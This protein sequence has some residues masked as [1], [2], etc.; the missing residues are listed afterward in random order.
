MPRA[1]SPAIPGARR[2][3]RCRH[4]PSAATP[5]RRSA[6][7]L[8]L[9]GEDRAGDLAASGVPLRTAVVYRAVKVERF[10]PDVAAALAQGALDGVLHFSRR[11]AQA[12]LDCATRVG[13]LERALA[14]VHFCLSGQVSQPLAAAG[15]AAIRL[16]PHPEE[17]AMIDL[18]GVA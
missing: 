14:P 18:V 6:P 12:Y 4:S 10:A 13:S 11:S 17:A 2:S 9:A 7:L 15:A 1:P 16:A 3:S 5:P 8:Y